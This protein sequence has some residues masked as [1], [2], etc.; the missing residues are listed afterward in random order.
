MKV[1]GNCKTCVYPVLHDI[2]PS[3]GLVC[4]SENLC[5]RGKHLV[6]GL[7][8]ALWDVVWQDLLNGRGFS[9]WWVADMYATEVACLLAI[10]QEKAFGLF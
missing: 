1:L 2:G 10:G 6:K 9:W 4:P 3:Y 8:V 7:A 5:E